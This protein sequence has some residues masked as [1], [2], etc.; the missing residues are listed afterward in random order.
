MKSLVSQKERKKKKPRTGPKEEVL[1]IVATSSSVCQ[2]SSE[3][4]DVFWEW[5]SLYKSSRRDQGI[6]SIEMVS[7]LCLWL[8]QPKLFCPQLRNMKPLDNPVLSHTPLNY[9]YLSELSSC[10]QG[11]AQSA[12]RQEKKCFRMLS[13]QN[14]RIKRERE[15]KISSGPKI[16]CEIKKKCII[17]F[18]YTPQ[19]GVIF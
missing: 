12:H 6:A 14:R 2:Q 16:S 11:W 9:C 3:H 19:N 10:G 7:A 1:D 8:N 4:M 13:K 18:F 17:A 15:K 5:N